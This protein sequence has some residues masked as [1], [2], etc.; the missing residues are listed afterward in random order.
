M[1]MLLARAPRLTCRVWT[2][3]RW[4]R[5]KG[6]RQRGSLWLPGGNSLSG[7]KTPQMPMSLGWENLQEGRRGKHKRKRAGVKL[8]WV[9]SQRR[10][11]DACI[12]SWRLAQRRR[13]SS[14]VVFIVIK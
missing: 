12:C 3:T 8:R 5:G 2:L 13:G 4:R 11:R 1:P 7:H 9:G 6:A 10:R 14:G